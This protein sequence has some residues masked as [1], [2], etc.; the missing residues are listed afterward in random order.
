[1][2]YDYDDDDAYDRYDYDGLALKCVARDSFNILPQRSSA[3][4]INLSPCQFKHRSQIVPVASP[5]LG[6]RRGTKLRENDSKVTHKNIMK[7]V[8]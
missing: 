8:Q 6:A 2:N 3:I 1:L 5:G 4:T 7:F